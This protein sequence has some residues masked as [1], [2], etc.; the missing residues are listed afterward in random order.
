[1][2]R[3]KLN[4]LIKWKNK[5]NRKPLILKG[6]RQVGKTWIL[7]E[8]GEKE[9]KNIA[10]FNFDRNEELGAIFNNTKDAKRILENL[11]LINGE[12]INPKDSLIIFDE[13]QECP[14]A[15]NALKYLYEDK[16]EYHITCAG[17]LLG[18]TLNGIAVGKVEFMQM[19][20]L[21]FKEFLQATGELRLET[22]M[23]QASSIY[24]V[25]E[26]LKDVMEEKLMQYYLIGGMP[27]AVIAWVENKDIGLVKEVQNA[28][29]ATYR[30]DFSK[31]TTKSQQTKLTLVWD[32]LPRQLAK[33]NK[34]FIY[35]L[36]RVGARAKNLEETLQWLI[37]A[38]LI[39]KVNWNSAKAL[40]L[41]P[42]DD[43]QVFKTY[44]LDVGLLANMAGLDSRLVLQKEK[45]FKEFKGSLAEN[46]ICNSLWRNFEIEPKYWSS[47][48][49][50][51]E[52][53]FIIQFE[54]EIIPIEVKASENIRS[55]SLKTF[56]EKNNSK[57]RVRYSL[58]S[59]SLDDNLL[60]I[61][62]YMADWSDKLITLALKER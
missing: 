49:S 44:L 36:V 3:E 52:V 29:V 5:K 18:L 46:Y 51:A 16:P 37:N 22:Q 26:V 62:L 27:E 48:S 1:M 6:A 34:K 45:L 33:E 24:E 50:H 55:K 15:L 25:I 43:G 2:N 8:F 21:S 42:Y 30:D 54:N 13:I 59:L 10:Y 40:P 11:A 39:E 14:E 61:P 12:A 58:R 32:S 7:K 23:E 31:H 17:S 53:D 20:P 9:F 60:N 35:S 41:R 4:D 56:S 19:G 47:D 38:G 57:L 28:L